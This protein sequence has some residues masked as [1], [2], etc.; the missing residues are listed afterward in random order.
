MDFVEFENLVK[1]ALTN[2]YDYAV[3]E[4]HPLANTKIIPPESY[5]HSKGEYLRTV[6][7]EAING[8]KPNEIEYD[9]LSNEW[10]AYIILS[11]RYIE[12]V[13]SHDLA[14]TLL[15]GERQIRRNQKKAIQAVALRLWDQFGL[16]EDQSQES[17]QPEFIINSE[18]INLYQVV[19]GVLSLL[20]SRFTQESVNVNFESGDTD[21]FINSDRIILRQIL[22]GVL[23]LLLQKED[24][25]EIQ[26]NI[27]KEDE[28]TA[29]KILSP[30][31]SFPKNHI[32]DQ[33]QSQESAVT[34]WAKE[35]NLGFHD[36]NTE[37]ENIFEIRF[38][39]MDKKSILIIDDQETALKMYKRYLS[40]SDYKIHG[41]SKATKVLNKAIELQPSIIL[42][43]IMMPKVDGWEVLQSLRLNEKTKHIPIIV[44][45][46]WGEPELAKSLGANHFL[47]K[48]IMQRELIDTLK[49]YLEI[50]N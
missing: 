36:E 17:E 6:L 27:S 25:S 45:S 47:S 26:I 48:P 9:T 50:E 10:R 41:L 28:F 34:Y 15:L 2:L 30:K 7:V 16:R 11:Q 3:L 32:L 14:K 5:K 13:S 37:E 39:Q 12:N 38:L 20:K 43:D 40:K 21:I 22:I 1:D 44:C 35:L 24:L 31:Q 18:K 29:I 4:A 49:Q 33:L 42:L 23:N 46:A 19:S 8:L